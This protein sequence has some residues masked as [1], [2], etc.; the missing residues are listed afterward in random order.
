MKALCLVMFL[1]LCV[2]LSFGCKPASADEVD[3][4]VLGHSWHFSHEGGGYSPNGWN[5][6]GGL[7]YRRDTWHGQW[8]AGGMQYRDSFRQHAYAVYGGYQF[9]QPIGPINVFAAVRAGYL[10]GSGHHGPGALPSVG[11]EYKRVALE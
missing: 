1:I 8:I 4:L 6:G 7:E 3:A 5:W 9:T 2:L 11:I 10:N